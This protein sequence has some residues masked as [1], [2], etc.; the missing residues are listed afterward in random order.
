MSIIKTFSVGNGD[1]FY[2]KHGAD[3]FT[4]IDCCYDSDDDWNSQLEEISEQQK[5]KGI[6]R[7]IST[8]P[9]DDHIKG[10]K[11]YN[12]RLGIDNFYCVQNEATKP[13]ETDDFREYTKLRDDEKKVFYLYKG[14]TRKWVNQADDERGSSGIQCLWPVTSNQYFKAALEKAQS[15]ESPNNISPILTYRIEEGASFMWLGDL[16]SDFLESVK[17]DISFSHI[18]VVF[19]PHHGRKSGRL[20][21]CVLDKLTPH[22]IIV[23]E[24]PASELAYYN[25]YNTI[26]QNTSGDITFYCNGSRIEIF[27]E[28]DSYSVEYLDDDNCADTYGNYIGTLNL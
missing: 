15:G 3:S 10:L 26:T 22:I 1:M 17:D 9:D 12:S 16:E 14:C 2:I 27:V 6:N 25:G 13:D 5:G 8:H 4:V 24:A 18:D 28:S 19:A 20:P 7:F 23:G 21:R 11:D